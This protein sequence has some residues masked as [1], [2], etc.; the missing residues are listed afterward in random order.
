MPS[1]AKLI[2]VFEEARRLVARPGN[3][4]IWASW[5]DTEHAVGEIDGILNTLRSGRLPVMMTVLFAPTGPMQELSIDSGWG[6]EFLDLA[7]RFDE[8]MA[9]D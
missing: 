4:F 1:V 8:A 7:D 3:E 5:R 6:H 9:R 2:P